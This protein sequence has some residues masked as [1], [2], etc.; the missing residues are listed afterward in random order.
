MPAMSNTPDLRPLLAPSSVA[1]VGL[2]TKPGSAGLVVLQNLLQAGYDGALHLVGRSGGSVGG[3]TVHTSIA[4]LPPGLDLAI[5]LVPSDAVLD[6]LKA[7]VERGVRG[8]VCFASGFAEMGEEGRTRQQLIAET[9]RAGGLAL[10]GPNTIGFFNS[11][12]GFHVSMVE[13]VL[14]PKLRPEDGPA[15]AVVAQSG[16]IGVHVSASLR[17]RG[18]PVSYVLTT[19]NEAQVGLSETLSFL[20]DDPSTRT[21]VV[22]AE[23]IRSA[24]EVLAAFG[25]MHAAGK[26]VVLL[27]PGRSEGAQAATSSHTGALAGNHGAMRLAAERA[28][29]LVVDSLE[30]AIDLGQ[31]MLRFPQPPV[32]GLGL[33]TASGALCGIALDYLEPLNLEMPPMS[34]PQVEAL[35]EQ[36]PAYTPPRNPLDLGTLIGPRPELITLGVVAEQDDPA[37]GSLLVSLPMPSPEIAPVWLD[38]HLLGMEGRTKPAIFVMQNED[39][40]L[41]P[42]MV[43]RAA[44]MGTVVMRSPERA[45]RA[46]ATFT[47]FGRL[48]AE[49]H[50]GPSQMSLPLSALPKLAGGTL[51]EWQGKQVLAAAGLATPPGALARSLEE[52]LATA[53]RI[54]YP[55]VMKAQAAA[56]AHKTEAGGVLLNIADEAALRQ[57]WQRLHDNIARHAPGM[58]L[59]GVLVETMAAKG[60]ELVVGA[61]RDAQWGP[62]LMLG[63]GGIW[64]EALGDV[65]LLSPD[66]PHAAIVA[67]LRSLKAAKLLQGFRGAPPVDLDAVARAVATI[68]ALML[69]RP[70]IAEIDVN[71]LLAY[72]PERGVLALDALV[73][74]R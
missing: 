28:G 53:A 46:L 69:Q 33:I 61:V 68:G 60:L 62:V 6:T 38:A 13:L 35:R 64:V 74:V 37:I 36:L 24:P 10:L 48:R 55:V 3:R 58:V 63:L 51:P 73:V 1:I 20:A 12:A 32:G 31:L 17:A 49:W 16:G 30:E 65:R 45:L 18:V 39:T 42:A 19:G 25:R 22:Y 66:L 4:E 27:H 23:Q 29:V 7:C 59:D 34:A 50:A 72:G 54:G 14:P 52:A 44:R 47:R 40:P 26:G 70:E 21:A 57:A 9:A 67:R 2:S 5:L 8:A 71:P 11:V 43:E 56:L 41:P 15:V